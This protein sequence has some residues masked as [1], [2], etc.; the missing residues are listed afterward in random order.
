MTRIV[1]YDGNCRLCETARQW[2]ARLDRRGRFRFV[3]FEAEEARRLQP[4]LVN[5]DYLEAI[6]LIE[7]DGRVLAGVPAVIAVVRLLPLGRP[8]AWFL[9]L[10]GVYPRARRLYEWIAHHRYR[11]F[12]ARRKA[13]NKK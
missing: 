6:R 10:P 5:V 13:N 7:P 3:H 2:V 11:L 12:G 1:I 9:T 4:D 8:T